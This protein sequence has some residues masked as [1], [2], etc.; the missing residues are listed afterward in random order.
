[1]SYIKELKAEI[2]RNR[3]IIDPD[4]EIATKIFL[5]TLHQQSKLS[6]RPSVQYF[7]DSEMYLPRPV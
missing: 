1:M 4:K 6:V 2:A 5:Q 7:P 3:T